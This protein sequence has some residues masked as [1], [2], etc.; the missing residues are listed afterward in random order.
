NNLV[1]TV[2]PLSRVRLN[3]T[4]SIGSADGRILSRLDVE[5]LAGSL[6]VQVRYNMRR[7]EAIMVAVGNADVVVE[8]GDVMV[9]D[10][11]EAMVA[12]VAGEA[13]VRPDRNDFVSTVSVLDS[14]AGLGARG[15]AMLNQ[16][17]FDSLRRAIPFSFEKVRAALPPLPAAT[18]A[19]EAP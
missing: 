19:L 14:G 4:R 7:P 11:A 16:A 17:V 18:Y 8:R 15:P 5:L 12:V 3:G 1:V 9:S 6:R 10:D 13:A 2:G